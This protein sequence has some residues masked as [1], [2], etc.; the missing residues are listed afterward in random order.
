MNILDIVF[1][2]IIVAF[3]FVTV[4]LFILYRVLNEMADAIK[5]LKEELKRVSKK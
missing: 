3:G 5:E 1:I 2:L 4:H